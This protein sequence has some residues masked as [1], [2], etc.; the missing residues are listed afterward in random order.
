MV[1]PQRKQRDYIISLQNSAAGFPRGRVK[2]A[3]KE[4][5]GPDR[6]PTL[7]TVITVCDG[8]HVF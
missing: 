7:L 3:T 4:V 1:K 6:P 8:E 5:G 2:Y